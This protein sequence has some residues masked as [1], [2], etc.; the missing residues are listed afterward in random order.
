MVG[1]RRGKQISRCAN[2][3]PRMIVLERC[4]KIFTNPF[5]VQK[6]ARRELV[7][8]FSVCSFAPERESN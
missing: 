1:L 7:M 6:A 3:L 8:Q 5:Q 2:L 4:V